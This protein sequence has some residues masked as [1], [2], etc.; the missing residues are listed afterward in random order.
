MRKSRAGLPVSHLDERQR[1]LLRRIRVTDNLAVY[2]SPERIADWAKLKSVMEM[3]GARWKVRKGFLFADDVDGAELVRVA[4]ESGQ[5]LDPKAAGFY[6]TP[7]E[8]ATRVVELADLQP[9]MRVLEPSAGKG[10]LA[11]A[12]LTAAHVELHCVELLPENV[13]ALRAGV[14]YLPNPWHVVEGDF[15]TMTPEAFGFFTRFYFD[16]I[17]MNP[18]FAGRADIA[19]VRHALRFLRP[20]GRLVAIMSAG[21]EHRQDRLATEFRAHVTASGGT[22]E[23]NPDGSFAE[24]G[25]QVRTV[26]VVIHAAAEK[27]SSASD[28]GP[29]FANAPSL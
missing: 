13:K 22:M 19:H 5:V 29:L 6:P 27:R 8:L 14:R 28:H 24:S 23:R 16:R 7:E 20:G 15:L 26:T 10:N 21:V 4:I 25:T 9:N 12:I 3:L 2:D 18:P 17:V 1:E 11:K